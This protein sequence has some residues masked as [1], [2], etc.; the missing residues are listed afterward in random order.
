MTH[1]FP[2]P[3][4]G[5]YL[6][7]PIDHAPPSEDVAD[8]GRREGEAA[9]VERGGVDERTRKAWSRTVRKAKLL[10]GIRTRGMRTWRKEGLDV[11]GG[12]DGDVWFGNG[13]VM[14]P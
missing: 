9:E 7:K 8:G 10:T 3:R 1:T 12:R 13:L 5:K 11:L 14:V 2:Q 4:K 6:H